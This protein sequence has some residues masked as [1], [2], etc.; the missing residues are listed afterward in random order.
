MKVARNGA[1]YRRPDG[2]VIIDPERSK[3]QKAI[4]EACP[5]GAVYWNDELGLPQK[6]TMC[7]H[8]LDK[9]YAAPRCVE[10][11]PNDALHFGDLDDPGSGISLAIERN[12]VT[13]DARTRRPGHR[14]HFISTFRPCSWREASICRATRSPPES[15]SRHGTGRPERS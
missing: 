4:A 2:I 10:A 1:V 12:S 5:I 14:G 7:A 3:G 13:P 11:C 6:C 8:L 9:G 15:R